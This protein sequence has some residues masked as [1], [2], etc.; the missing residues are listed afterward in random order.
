[1]ASRKVDD[2][3][4]PAESNEWSKLAPAISHSSPDPGEKPPTVDE[5]L[6]A[7]RAEKPVTKNE[8]A[9][10]ESENAPWK[11]TEPQKTQDDSEPATFATIVEREEDAKR[12]AQAR[13]IAVDDRPRALGLRSVLIAL[14]VPVTI[15][16]LAIRTIA[17]SAFLW[18]T[19]HRPGFPADSYGFSTDER[20]TYGS[21]GME[22]VKSFAPSSYLADL[23]T[24][25]GHKLFL[26]SEVGHMSDVKTVLVGA[27]VVTVLLALLA[28]I[29]S[30]SLR[31]RAPGVIRR[32]LFAGSLVTLL[33]M[34][35]LGILG[36]LG[37]NTFFE[38]FHHLFFPQG[39]WQFRMS[40]TLI[41][42]Y[43][44]QFWVD[45]AIAVAVITLLL[46]LL[47]MVLTWPTAYRRELAKR[48]AEE[49]LEVRRRLTLGS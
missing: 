47:L 43:P 9:P 3:L 41:R 38:T 23:R 7:R 48:R 33:L 13:E 24:P 44:P 2:S 21:Y 29:A 6:G 30:R 8:P 14:T 18:F 19:Y 12:R 5:L 26:T 16:M 27:T 35:V 11:Q 36:A 42:L 46:S 40:D 34:L 22:Y 25:G 28:L 15:I 49:R 1:M 39:N 45:A 37:W 20:M 4:S 32:S 10:G 17:S 31:N